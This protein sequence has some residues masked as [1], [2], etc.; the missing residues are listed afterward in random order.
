MAITSGA[1]PDMNGCALPLFCN[2]NNLEELPNA[3]YL[4]SKKTSRHQNHTTSP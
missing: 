3:L 1:Q 4:K 2:F